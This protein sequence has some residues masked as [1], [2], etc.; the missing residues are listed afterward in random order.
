M[1]VADPQFD[2]VITE[3]YAMLYRFAWSLT[4]NEAESLD[5]T[6]QTFYLWAIKRGPMRDASKL[7]SWLCKTLYREFL[8]SRRHAQRFPQ[9]E[10]SL[11]EQELPAVEPEIIEKMDAALVM[12][13][14]LDLA[15][16]FRAPLMLFYAEDRSYQEIAHIL[17]VPLGTVMSR[18]ARGKQELR[19][20][21][22]TKTMQAP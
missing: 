19:R 3:H 21:L 1:S 22:A 18:L 17:G 11:V 8:S 12:E 6:H 5:L 10:V 2:Q 7:K 13:T 4:R 15:E 16:I 9:V 14:L 20:L